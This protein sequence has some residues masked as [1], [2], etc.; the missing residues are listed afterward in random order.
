MGT[1]EGYAAELDL[2]LEYFRT[3]VVPVDPEESLEVMA[4][5]TAADRSARNGG[6]PVR[7]VDVL[8]EAGRK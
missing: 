6:K 8:R 4:F 3:G 5:M 2:I 1:Y 7:I